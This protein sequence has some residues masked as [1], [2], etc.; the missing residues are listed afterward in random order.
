METYVKVWQKAE[1]FSPEAG[2]PLAWLTTMLATGHRPD[3]GRT[4][5]AFQGQRG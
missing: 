5:G 4:C 3:P 2:H 1:R